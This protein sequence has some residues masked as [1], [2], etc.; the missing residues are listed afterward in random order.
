[1]RW[2]CWGTS[3]SKWHVLS[4]C[5]TR[6][7]FVNNGHNNTDSDAWLHG[8]TKK[9]SLVAVA[10]AYRM[11]QRFG[12]TTT[13][14]EIMHKATQP[15]ACN[16]HITDLMESQEDSFIRDETISDSS[17]WPRWVTPEDDLSRCK[18]QKKPKNPN[19]W[20]RHRNFWWWWSK[21]NNKNLTP[22][23]CSASVYT[24]KDIQMSKCTLNLSGQNNTIG[25][26]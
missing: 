8:C 11:I 9:G 7:N 16:Y 15:E 21:Y 13:W 1:M 20:T 24:L 23:M 6:Q 19:Y 17:N 25:E 2:S 5:P 22:S 4:P 18:L 12:T 10:S 3:V 26:W 14:P